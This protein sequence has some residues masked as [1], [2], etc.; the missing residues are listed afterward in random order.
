[1]PRTA[2]TENVI[3]QS[4]RYVLRIALAPHGLWFAELFEAWFRALE[5]SKTVFSLYP[6][7]GTVTPEIL[8]RNN[9]FFRLINEGLAP[10]LRRLSE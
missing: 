1:M 4:W 6:F 7:S 2:I 8:L 3:S 5:R 9:R 10:G